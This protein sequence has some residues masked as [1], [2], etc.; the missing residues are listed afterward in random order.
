MKAFNII[1]ELTRDS[2]SENDG[3]FTADSASTMY[4]YLQQMFGKNIEVIY[5]KGNIF[6]TSS[7]EL[8]F[9]Y[10]YNNRLDRRFDKEIY[11]IIKNEDD[12][13]YIYEIE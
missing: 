5:D 13:I 1:D 8:R 2:Y 12:L 7:K 6:Q 4:P 10:T 3:T 11:A 9:F